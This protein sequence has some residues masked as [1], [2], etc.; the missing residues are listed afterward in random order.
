MRVPSNIILQGRNSFRK[1]VDRAGSRYFANI[2]DHRV[3]NDR[4]PSDSLPKRGKMA[5][6]L[7]T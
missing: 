3:R 4:I 5:V 1:A 6:A 7:R 2:G